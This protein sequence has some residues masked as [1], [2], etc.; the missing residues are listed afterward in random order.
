MF[1]FLIFPYINVQDFHTKVGCDICHL[2]EPLQYFFSIMYPIQKQWRPENHILSRETRTILQFLICFSL[3]WNL[4]EITK[5]DFQ[6]SLLKLQYPGCKLE[7][8]CV[9]N[10]TWIFLFYLNFSKTIFCI[11]YVIGKLFNFTSPIDSW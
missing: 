5:N 8:L 11:D 1:V 9:F 2:K 4:A 3:N 10:F 7:E 6:Q